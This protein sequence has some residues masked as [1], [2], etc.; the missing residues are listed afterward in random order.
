MHR[1]SRVKVGSGR[2]SADSLKRSRAICRDDRARGQQI[3]LEAQ[4]QYFAGHRYR[5]DRDRN[6]RYNYGDQWGDIVCVDGVNMTEEAYIKTQ[7]NVPLKNNLIRRLVRN[8][9]GAYSQQSTEPR[10]VARDR[11]EQPE[12]ETLNVLLEY[13]MQLNETDEMTARA[14]EEF[15]I[16]GMPVQRKWVG[17]NSAKQKTD[18][19]TSSIEPNNFIIDSNMRDFRSWDCTFVGEIHDLGY[20][21]LMTQFAK[22]PEDYR[23]LSEIYKQARDVMGGRYTWEDFGFGRYR[24]VNKEFLSP[25]DPTRCRVIEVWRLESKPRYRCHDWNS[26][27]VYKI[28]IEDAEEVNAENRR[29]W[30]QAKGAGIPYEEVPWIEAEWFMDSYWYYYRLSPFGDILDEGETPYDHKSHPYVFKPYPFIDGE[31]HSFVADVIDQQRYTN[32]LIVMQDFIIKASAKGALLVPEDCLNGIDP[33]TFADSWAKF[34]GVIV[35]KPSTKHSHVPQQVSANSVNI[36]VHELLSLQLKFFEDISGVNGALQGKASFAG[37]SGSHAQMMAQ[38]ASTSLIDLFNSFNSFVREGAY[39]DMKNIQQY[40]DEKKVRQIV[41]KTSVN[42]K[43][44]LD[45]EADISIVQSPS[46]QQYKAWANDFL[47]QLFNAKAISIEQLLSVAKDLPYADAL[48]QSIQS[49]K[50]TLEQGQIPEGLSPQLAQ[51]AQS[52]ADPRAMQLLTQAM[53][54]DGVP[55]PMAQAA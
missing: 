16:G 48:L 27:D 47:M 36:G 1:L 37:E 25:I 14:L 29:R 55:Q 23:R 13:N 38:S 5:E 40:Y 3:L 34:N 24:S 52:G 7:G 49:Q 32:R 51:Q 39:K 44:I 46:S 21:E 12:A 54:G 26:G 31:I 17:W 18:C 35:Y 42:L 41:G 8:V 53:G 9:M 11:D 33:K 50:A 19:W 28:D 22:S 43:K 6:K 15:L 30:E 45:L 4:G 2:E 20:N 10:C